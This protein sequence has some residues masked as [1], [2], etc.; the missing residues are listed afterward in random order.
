MYYYVS[1]WADLKYIL[2]I[3]QL[4]ARDMNPKN[5]FLR[6]EVIEVNNLNI[7]RITIFKLLLQAL[8]DN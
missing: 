3:N 5:N 2:R 8:I 4:N 7:S 1:Y 6:S